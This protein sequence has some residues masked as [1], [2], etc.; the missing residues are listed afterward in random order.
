MSPT[1]TPR[2]I[3]VHPHACGEYARRA[4]NCAKPLG[5]PPR[6]WGIP[7]APLPPRRNGRF[8]PT[9][10]GNTRMQLS[11]RQVTTVHPHA[12]GEYESSPVSVPALRGS[13]PRVWGILFGFIPRL[14]VRRFTPTR[15]GNTSNSC[16]FL[17]AMSVHPHACGEYLQRPAPGVDQGGS[18]PRVWGIRDSRLTTFQVNRFTPTRVGN[19]PLSAQATRPTP[20]HPHAC[21][22]YAV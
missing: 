11:P 22:E 21:G 2:H 3:A 12:C 5:S 7:T 18:P 10:V 8:T 13:P 14:P 17:A 4:G 6:V 19:T 1:T 9:R 16:A 20:V 15:V